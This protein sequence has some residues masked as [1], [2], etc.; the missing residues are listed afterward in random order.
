MDQNSD[1]ELS[2]ECS[3]C[4]HI[5]VKTRVD[6][7]QDMTWRLHIP[8]GPCWHCGA[9]YTMQGFAD[10]FKIAKL[11]RYREPV[12]PETDDEDGML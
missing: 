7:S 1:Y 6:V 9:P 2:I 12:P 10:S 8:N 11:E 3:V 4:H 5:A